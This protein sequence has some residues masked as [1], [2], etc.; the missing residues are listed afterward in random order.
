MCKPVD[1]NKKKRKAQC[2]RKN[3]IYIANAQKNL[4]K[5]EKI[6]IFP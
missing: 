1:D 2:K 5:S 4:K 6:K 3:P